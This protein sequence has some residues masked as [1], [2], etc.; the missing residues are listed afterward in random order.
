MFPTVFND[1]KKFSKELFKY[2]PIV[3]ELY[4]LLNNNPSKMNDYEEIKKIINYMKGR[5]VTISSN[6]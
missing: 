1:G 2:K 4:N 6:R 5:W 3:D